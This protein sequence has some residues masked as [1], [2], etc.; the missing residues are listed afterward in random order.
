MVVS[1][2]AKDIKSASEKAYKELN[3]ISFE[4]MYY[5]RDLGK[6]LLKYKE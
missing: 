6:D 2:M 4:N 3:K 5:R 1:A